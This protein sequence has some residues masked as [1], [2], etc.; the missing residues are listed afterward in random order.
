MKG[1]GPPPELRLVEARG[2]HREE[3]GCASPACHPGGLTK[4]KTL[5]SP[6]GIIAAHCTGPA[7]FGTSILAVNP[8]VLQR[9]SSVSLPHGRMGSRQC[10]STLLVA[11][12]CKLWLCVALQWDGCCL[13]PEFASDE[14][15]PSAQ[16]GQAPR[17]WTSS[18]FP[19]SRS[20]GLSLLCVIPVGVARS[21]VPTQVLKRCGFVSP[22]AR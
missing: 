1:M 20:L 21:D 3:L 6:R 17:C 5:H 12:P 16:D 9:C 22:K 14:I 4:S 15:G 2:D 7:N 11:A 10:Q 19:L 18:P 13:T 8:P